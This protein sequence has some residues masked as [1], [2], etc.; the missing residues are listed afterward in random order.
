MRPSERPSGFRQVRFGYRA[1]AAGS[2]SL[3]C[4]AGD[5]LPQVM[6]MS[7]RTDGEWVIDVK[8]PAG[9]YRYGYVVDDRWCSG[10]VCDGTIELAYTT[11][12]GS[13]AV[14]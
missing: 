7:R 9:R 11:P 5:W 1:P 2:V 6:P 14:A 12:T 3:V 4:V 10:A 8:L 13:H